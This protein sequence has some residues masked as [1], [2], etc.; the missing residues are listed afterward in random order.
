M[1]HPAFMEGL[2]GIMTIVHAPIRY[3]RHHDKVHTFGGYTWHDDKVHALALKKA[4]LQE[5][6]EG[7]GATLFPR[8]VDVR[9]VALAHIRA[10]EVPEARGR[11]LVS[12]ENTFS[13]KTALSALQAAFPQ[14]V[15]QEGVDSPQVREL[16]SSKVCVLPLFGSHSRDLVFLACGN[17]W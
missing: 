9:D 4:C 10:A 3:A 6:A 16:N 12:W 7:K 15:F 1:L 17:K 11:Y 2:R 8:M 5:V 14:Y 13:T